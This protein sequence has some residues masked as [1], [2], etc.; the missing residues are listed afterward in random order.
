M[1]NTDLSAFYHFTTN[2]NQQPQGHGFRLTKKSMARPLCF[3]HRQMH[4]RPHSVNLRQDRYA[5]T[6]DRCTDDR[7]VLIYGKTAMLQP[8][9]DAQTTTQC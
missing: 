5:S 9:T 3:H 1:Q 6:T 2:N 8:Q 7:T 4:R